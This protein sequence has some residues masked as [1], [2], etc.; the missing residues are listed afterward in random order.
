MGEVSMGAWEGGWMDV[1]K[2]IN[3]PLSVCLGRSNTKEA[4][5]KVMSLSNR[6]S[7]Q[8][9]SQMVRWLETN[10]V[11]VWVRKGVGEVST[12]AWEGGWMDVWVCINALLS[13]C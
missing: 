6:P 9:G 11:C 5:M 10:T 3:V 7:N 13:V 1:W 2:C 4:A 12:C 8:K